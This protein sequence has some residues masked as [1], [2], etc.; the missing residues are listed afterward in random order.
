MTSEDK[1]TYMSETLDSREPRGFATNELLGAWSNAALSVAKDVAVV[2]GGSSL[3]MAVQNNN[4]Q[5]VE[6]VFRVTQLTV[7]KAAES[8]YL[9]GPLISSP[10]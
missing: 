8:R 4:W 5:N 7:Q 6:N 2:L 10:Q 1:A 3:N 9:F